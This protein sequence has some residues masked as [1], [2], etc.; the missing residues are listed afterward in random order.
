MVTSSGAKPGDCIIA[1]KS[2]G[3]EGTAIIAFEKEKELKA[4]FGKDFV[5]K[6]KGFIKNIS[7]VKEGVIAG[8]FGVSA[9][10]DVTEGGI[11]GALWEIAEASG[12][13][14]VV[15]K[16]DIPLE[17]ETCKI[18]EYYGIDALKLIS[19]GCM[20]V[21]CADGNG[22]VNKL[23]ESG[24]NAVII[25]KVTDNKRKILIDGEVIKEIAQ[26]GSD[27]LYKIV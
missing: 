14:I 19:S 11:L 17:G 1:T 20:L 21:T 7:V 18:C 16:H 26:P 4:V 10:H 27:E 24:I 12:V 15:Y 5:D 22:L 23:L 8:K 13:G 3:I 25:G 6:A 2:A 9:M